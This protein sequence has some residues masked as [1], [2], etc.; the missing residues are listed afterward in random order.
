MQTTLLL[1]LVG[2]TLGISLGCVLAVIRIFGPRPLAKLA[3]GYVNF[4]RAIPLIL[5]IFWMFFLMPFVLRK[6]TGNPYLSVGAMYS[7]VIALVLAES[8][9][10]CEIIRA[11]IGSV[12]SGQMAAGKAIGMTTLQCLRWVILPQAFRNM[13]PALVNQSIGLLK[14]TSLVYVISL[15]D[16]LGAAGQMGLRNGQLVEFYLFAAAI[17]LLICSAGVALVNHLQKKNKQAC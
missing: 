17:Y 5:T 13:S 4:F 16:F 10:Y 9:Y 11:G 6:I 2:M 3:A 15:N 14:D 8:A 12:K 1:V 7:A